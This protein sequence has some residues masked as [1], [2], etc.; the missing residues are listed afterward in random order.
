MDEKKELETEK[1]EEFSDIREIAEIARE[2]KESTRKKEVQGTIT[3]SESPENERATE[4]ELFSALKIVAPGTNLRIALDGALKTG[5]GALIVIE[6]E[7]V[8]ALLDGGFKVNCRFTPQKLIELTKMDGAIILSKDV[9]KINN[10]N[11]LLAPDSKIRTAETGTRHKAAERTAKQTGA[12]TIAI[13]ERK[14]EI[15]LFFKNIKYPLRGTDEIRRKVNEQI[16]M[17]EKQRELFDKSIEKLDNLEL[18]NYPSLIQAAN[19]MQKGRMILKIADEMKKHIIEL[20]NEGTLHKTR[21]KELTANVEKETNF[22]IKDYTKLDLKK[23]KI[24]I[25]SLTYDEIFDSSNIFKARAYENIKQNHTVRGWRVL[26]KTSLQESDM[27]Q[28]I[29]NTG[30][31]GEIIHSNAQIYY[32]ILGQ[33]K[34]ANFK[35]EIDRIKLER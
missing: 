5:K 1:I 31:L 20:G 11:V 30:N 34:A 33:E 23:S 29:K 24:L 27:A 26:S 32:H 35:N 14:N 18:R 21:L 8:L 25:E 22:I 28:V 13:S 12:L 7:K 19:A 15:N 10:A 6:N 16:Q 9:K 4:E 17:L 3:P 2:I